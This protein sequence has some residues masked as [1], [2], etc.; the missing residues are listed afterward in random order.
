MKPSTF[1]RRS[2]LSA[3]ALSASIA[4]YSAFA[5]NESEPNDSFI[6][7]NILAPGDVTF[8][9]NLFAAE[10]DGGYGDY[11]DGGY[12]DSLAVSLAEIEG[13]GF[14]LA[15]DVDFFTFSG[16]TPGAAF[17]IDIN[18]LSTEF[19]FF[20]SLLGLFDDAGALIAANAE[21]INDGGT[22]RS[23]FGAVGSS[24][25]LNLAI[26]GREDRDFEGLHFENSDYSV[27]LSIGEEFALLPDNDELSDGTFRF[28]NVQVV[29]GEIIYIDPEI[30]IGYDFTSSVLNFGSVTLPA[31]PMDTMFTISFDDGTGTITENVLSNNEFLFTD[32]V[33]AGVSSFTV[34][35]IDVSEM[36]DPTNPLAFTTAVS[37]LGSGTTDVTQTAITINVPAPSALALFALG[38]LLLRRRVAKR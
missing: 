25:N 22:E 1:I 18:A 8:L 31:L 28:T 4:S 3:L 17:A 27:S 21:F 32:F 29:D 6:E 38:G 34:N 11:G 20:S 5:A 13:S 23:L 2:A 12:G 15:G 33:A 24:G 10:G 36:I 37:F 35:G 19:G 16:L 14:T 30:A 7:R 26:T 9:G